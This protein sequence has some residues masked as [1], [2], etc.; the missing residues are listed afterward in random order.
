MFF[1][2]E[3]KKRKEKYEPLSRGARKRNY[4]K[5]V[6]YRVKG[7]VCHQ[8]CLFKSNK[9]IFMFPYYILQANSIFRMIYS[10]TSKKKQLNIEEDYV[11]RIE[12]HKRIIFKIY[13]ALMEE[14]KK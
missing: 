7:N 14:K 8:W 4:R 3:K 5:K 11:Y 9:F 6:M 2:E 1:D 12:Q 10:T 13:S